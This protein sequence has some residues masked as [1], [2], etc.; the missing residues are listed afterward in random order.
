VSIAADNDLKAHARNDGYD[1]LFTTSDG[2]T[3]IP[4]EREGYDSATG[5]LTAWVNVPSVSSASN[6][7]IY[8]Y[9]GFGSAPD[10]SHTAQ[11]WNS[12][13]LGVW[14]LKENAVDGSHTATH[15]DSTVNGYNGLQNNNSQI[16]GKIG[17]AQSFNGVNDWINVNTHPVLTSQLTLE[18]WVYLNAL[19][20]DNKIV[21][22]LNRPSGT[23][24]GFTM[25]VGTTGG[26]ENLYSEVRDT[27][28]TDYPLKKGSMP[29]NSW[30]YLAST[31]VTGGQF[32]GY[33][34][35]SQLSPI[36]ASANNIGN[37]AGPM[38]IGAPGWEQYSLFFNGRIDEL[39]ISNIARS[40][41]WIGT[42]Y[43]TTNSPSTFEYIGREESFNCGNGTAPAYVQS[44]SQSF[45]GVK[46]ASITLPGSSTSGD[47]LILSFVYGNQSATPLTVT[48][49]RGNTYL[50]TVSTNIGGWGTAYTYYAKNIVGG[51]GPI[52]TTVTLNGAANSEFDL[53]LLEY[54]GVDTVAPLDQTS[55]G[56]G[57]GI[58]MDSGAKTITKAPSLIYGFGADDNTC[59]SNS[60]YTDRET[61]NGQCAADQTVIATGSYRV[62]ATQSPT[63][64]WILQMV[65]FKGA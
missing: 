30:N 14:H 3:A 41:E 16:A 40:P 15:Y 36:A 21:G 23:F 20:G 43:N 1:I 62:T 52:T 65:T 18:A 59:H 58:P 56:S 53:Y 28:G 42:S 31:W 47:L 32:I 34:N 54:A 25:A 33:I 39:R 22:D 51:P 35:G 64:Q 29:L 44:R 4:Y 55:A 24:Y 26:N 49:S 19:Q 8:L 45:G 48:D 50:A 13:Y 7:T 63:G 57:N 46:Q 61:A 9:Y 38:I 37:A 5:A 10:M 17:W 27:T 11:T 6:T 60:P 2:Q 12:N